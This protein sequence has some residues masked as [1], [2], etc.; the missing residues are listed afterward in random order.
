MVNEKERLEKLIPSQIDHKGKSEQRV[1][2]YNSGSLNPLEIA[3]FGSVAAGK[4]TFMKKVEELLH[5]SSTGIKFKRSEPED[6]LDYYPDYGIIADFARKSSRSYDATLGQDSLIFY[7]YL[8]KTEQVIPFGFIGLGGHSHAEELYHYK[9]PDVAVY[10]IDK[11]LLGSFDIEI[12]KFLKAEKNKD[13]D[14]DEYLSRDIYEDEKFAQLLLS[15]PQKYQ[16]FLNLRIKSPEIPVVGIVSKLAKADLLSGRKIE[17]IVKLNQNLYNMAL[18][19]LKRHKEKI[20]GIVFLENNFVIPES[21][22]LEGITKLWL[23]FYDDKQTGIIEAVHA[24]VVKSLNYAGLPQDNVKLI[25]F[26]DEATNSNHDLL[27][28]ASYVLK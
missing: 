20:E 18:P 5:L 14:A 19:I 15:I 24:A 7:A 10:F 23:P 28:H 27:I 22:S 25:Y 13:F 11:K 17:N 9:R 8:Q 21:I 3:L 1:M 16:Q 4:S 6:I 12:R 2:R 26:G